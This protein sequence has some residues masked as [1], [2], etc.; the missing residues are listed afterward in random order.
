MNALLGGSTKNVINGISGRTYFA[1]TRLSD[2]VG[3]GPSQVIA[4]LDEHPDSINDCLF[5]EN[6]GCPPGQEKWEDLPA[7]HHNSAGSFSFVDGHSEIHKWQ[8]PRGTTVYPILYGSWSSSP[9]P[10]EP[11][12]GANLG[13]SV[14][15]EWVDD[16]LPYIY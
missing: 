12:Y 6:A 9:G 11:G 1:P 10:A 8:N 7:S 2:L 13:V 14:D 3:N 15:Y 5:Y 4:W 16:R